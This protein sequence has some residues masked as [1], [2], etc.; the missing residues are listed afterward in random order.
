MPF[1]LTN[2]PAMFQASMHEVFGPCLREAQVKYLGHIISGKG[3]STDPA[4]VATMLNWP[5]PTIV[6]ELRGFLGLTRYY[7]RFIERFEIISKPLTNL[8]KKGGFYWNEQ[9]AAA[10][11]ELKNAVVRAL[12]LA[13]PD[14]SIPFVVE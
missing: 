3:V 5:Y 1:G 8:L 2:A 4:K 7:R 13:L 11:D 6:K 12:V 9:A 14:F 10:F